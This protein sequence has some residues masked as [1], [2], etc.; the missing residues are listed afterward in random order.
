MKFYVQI[1]YLNFDGLMFSHEIVMCVVNQRRTV[2]FSQILV[3]FW[4]FANVYARRRHSIVW[5]SLSN[6][7]SNL[8]RVA[9]LKSTL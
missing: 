8:D 3:C 6:C 1:Y 4:H 2:I 7:D 5:P 9:V